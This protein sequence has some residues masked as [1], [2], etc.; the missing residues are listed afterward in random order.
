MLAIAGLAVLR[1]WKHEQD[2]ALARQRQSLHTFL[3]SPEF[4]RFTREMDARLC[5]IINLIALHPQIVRDAFPAVAAQEQSRGQVPW[6]HEVM[7]LSASAVQR[8]EKLVRASR[9]VGASLACR[10]LVFSEA[11]RQEG[12]RAFLR[13]LLPEIEAFARRAPGRDFPALYF[14]RQMQEAA[15]VAYAAR[16]GGGAGIGD[17]ERL[18]VLYAATGPLLQRELEQAR[19]APRAFAFLAPH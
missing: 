11:V 9:A 5:T 16:H 12:H 1:W 3:R 13:A 6:S 19:A 18:F 10:G 4:G 14:D 15:L 8:P 2:A 7:P 17:V